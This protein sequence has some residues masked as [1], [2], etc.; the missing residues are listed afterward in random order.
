MTAL[1]GEDD[2]LLVQRAM[3]HRGVASTLVYA[4]VADERVAEEVA[5]VDNA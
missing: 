4:R 2:R 5:A 1:H 3:D